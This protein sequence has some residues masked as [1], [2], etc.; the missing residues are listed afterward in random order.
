MNQQQ[1]NMNFYSSLYAAS[2]SATARKPL[3]N[4]QLLG[5][6]H[7]AASRDKYIIA[8][9]LQIQA[10]HHG[11]LVEFVERERD[12]ERELVAWLSRRP[13]LLE[14][15]HD[16]VREVLVSIPA[17]WGSWQ[18]ELGVEGSVE[19]LIARQATRLDECLMQLRDVVA[20]DV[21]RQHERAPLVLGDALDHNAK[22]MNPDRNSTQ[23]QPVLRST[24]GSKQP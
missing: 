1:F 17:I 22:T 24:K 9:A 18:V 16:P 8:A 15:W 12:G 20:L 11:W 3:N 21:R 19:T 23:Q 7:M 2:V 14:V 5:W 13:F 4:D 6:A 10:Q